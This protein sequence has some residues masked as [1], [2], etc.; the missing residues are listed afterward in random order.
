VKNFFNK[1]NLSS[2]KIKSII[3]SSI[4]ISSIIISGCNVWYD[5]TTYFNLYYNSKDLFEEAELSILEQRKDI[6]NVNEP[7]IPNTANQTLTKVIEKCSKI[8][9]FNSESSFVDNALFM[10]GKAFYYQKLFPRAQRKFN[11]L[12]SKVPDSKLVPEAE[13]WIAKTQIQLRNFDAALDLLSSLK[14]KA[15]V[16]E[17]N[18]LL[19]LIY[20]EEIRAHIKN[21]RFTEALKIANDL[22]SIANDNGILSQTAYEIG[23]LNYRLDNYKSASDAYLLVNKYSP[24]FDYEFNSQLKHSKMLRLLNENEKSLKVLSDIRSEDK[25]SLSYDVIDLEMGL[26]FRQ[27]ERYNDAY[28]KFKYVDTA[29]SNSVTAGLARYEMGE[30]FEIDIFNYDSA[31]VYFQKASTSTSNVDYSQKIKNKSQLFNKY[32]TLIGNQISFSKQHEYLTDSTAFERDSIEYAQEQ[33]KIQEESQSNTSQFGDDGGKTSQTSQSATQTRTAPQ[34]PN[35]SLDSIAVLF[36]KNSFELGNLFFTELFV[37]DSAYY[38]YKTV[39]DNYPNSKIYPEALYSLGTYYFTVGD[40]VIGDSIYQFIYNNYRTLP[41][42]NAVAHQLNKTLI[43]L[44]FDPARDIYAK[45]EDKLLQAEYSTSLKQFYNIYKEF[46]KS[47]YAPK[48]LYTSGWIL[49]EKLSMKDSAASVYDSLVTKYPRSQ[50]ALK[51]NPKLAF[52]K[53]EKTRLE[54]LRQDS[55][56]K[57]IDSLRSI[58]IADSIMKAAAADTLKEIPVEIDEKN[59]PEEPTDEPVVENPEK[60]S[61]KQDE[62]ETPPDENR[63]IVLINNF[64][65][66]IK[67]FCK[68]RLHPGMV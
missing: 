15:A 20:V 46:P 40:S 1:L 64:Q 59:V 52:F 8:L 48:S 2:N 12:I 24:S 10:T 47:D 17:N 67:L 7:S 35:V 19:S 3:I 30:M 37:Y 21:E 11:E 43:D 29:F 57:T 26:V 13:L 28:D 51:V 68:I 33:E 31:F 25:N 49:E 6:Y 42:V 22:L 41:I 9:Q 4:F 54:N 56:K 38:Y 60:Q 58:E 65:Y 61:E 14:S 18:E 39:V 27:L 53:Q 32:R 5:F 55:I 44:N 16:N 63:S 50:Y 45:A 62:E 66:K 34:R 36:T 23:E